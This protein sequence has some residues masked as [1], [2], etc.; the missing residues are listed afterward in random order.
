MLNPDGHRALHDEKSKTKDAYINVI[1]VGLEI[2]NSGDFITDLSEKISKY[3]YPYPSGYT[4]EINK[5]FDEISN[6]KKLCGD[7]LNELK[8]IKDLIRIEE[9]T[10]L[11][12]IINK[13]YQLSEDLI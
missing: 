5:I 7:F 12:R 4:T 9:Y 2:K 1:L 13:M 8:N 3:K 6:L 10:V 11:F